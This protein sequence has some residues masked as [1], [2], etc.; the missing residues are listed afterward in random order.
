VLLPMLL[1]LLVLERADELRGLLTLL[2][3]SL[4]GQLLPANCTLLTRLARDAGCARA[5]T[6]GKAFADEPAFEDAADD[7]EG[8]CLDDA[9]TDRFTPADADVDDGLKGEREAV[10]GVLVDDARVK[11]RLWFGGA[12]V[13]W[14]EAVEDGGVLWGR[15]GDAEIVE[16]ADETLQAAI[17]GHDFAYSRRGGCE[18]D[19]M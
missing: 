14:Q 2:T 11:D 15:W 7:V 10:G 3:R 19:E 6:E 13:G 16:D 17:H 4:V 8:A 12:I 9:G 5:R 18:V 1:V